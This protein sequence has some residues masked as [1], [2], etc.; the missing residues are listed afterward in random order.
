MKQIAGTLNRLMIWM[1]QMIP[2]SSQSLQIIYDFCTIRMPTKA[3]LTLKA[4]L[5][6]PNSQ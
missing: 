6:T 4:I 5:K 3:S 2:D 1:L